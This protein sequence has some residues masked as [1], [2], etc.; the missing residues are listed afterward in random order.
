MTPHSVGR[1]HAVTE[2][3]ARLGDNPLAGGETEG[4]RV[5]LEQQS[6]TAQRISD[7][8]TYESGLKP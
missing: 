2:G 4:D 8:R 3:T 1:C 7:G 6:E 5:P